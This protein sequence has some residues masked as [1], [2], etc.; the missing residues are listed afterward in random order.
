MQKISGHKRLMS[1][2]FK[3]SKYLQYVFWQAGGANQ[4]RN[5]NAISISRIMIVAYI[6]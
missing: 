6:L 3:K 1:F 4:R 5:D 2:F